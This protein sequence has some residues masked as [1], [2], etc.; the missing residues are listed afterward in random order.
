[1]NATMGL[2]AIEGK[3]GEWTFVLFQP[4]TKKLLRIKKFEGGIAEAFFL[5]EEKAQNFKT[6]FKMLAGCFYPRSNIEE[7][8]Q[9]F[10]ETWQPL[11]EIHLLL[12]GVTIKVSEENMDVARLCKQ[13]RQ[14]KVE[15]QEKK[16][17]CA[18]ELSA[19]TSEFRNRELTMQ[20]KLKRRERRRKWMKQTRK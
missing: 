19:K 6:C 11:K 5:E 14:M 9:H 8:L 2:T 4:P 7:S 16:K 15:Q 10:F 20:Q 12:A 17:Q 18:G 3:N 13:F 1:M